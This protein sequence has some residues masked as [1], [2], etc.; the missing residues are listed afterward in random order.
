MNA[1]QERRGEVGFG[2]SFGPIP[3]LPNF[4]LGTHTNTRMAYV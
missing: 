4:S 2:F 1:G 3:V